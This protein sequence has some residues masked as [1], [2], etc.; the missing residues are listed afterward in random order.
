MT[1]GNELL[2][3]P[4]W[5]ECALCWVCVCIRGRANVR[6]CTHLCAGFLVWG[7]T[8]K[9]LIHMGVGFYVWCEVRVHFE[10][11]G[12][13]ALPTPFLEETGL[14]PT[15]AHVSYAL[16]GGQSPATVCTRTLDKRRVWRGDRARTRWVIVSGVR[17]L[18]FKLRAAGGE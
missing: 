1:T 10:A 18:D 3:C 16:V 7:L 17:S 6:M 14:F 5:T 2:A 9:Y 11:C 15:W 13:P 4:E 8:F 12:R